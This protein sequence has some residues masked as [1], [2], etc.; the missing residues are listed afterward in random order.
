MASGMILSSPILGNSSPPVIRDKWIW[1][2]IEMEEQEEGWLSRA[3]QRMAYIGLPGTNGVRPLWIWNSGD[4]P[5]EQQSIKMSPSKILG[6]IQE[7]EIRALWIF[8]AGRIDDLVDCEDEELKALEIEAIVHLKPLK[9]PSEIPPPPPPPPPPVEWSP[10]FSRLNMKAH[11]A[12]SPNWSRFKKPQPTSVIQAAGKN[13]PSLQASKK[14]AVQ[15]RKGLSS[16]ISSPTA[17]T[18]SLSP[19][20]VSLSSM[21]SPKSPLEIARMNLRKTPNGQRIFSELSPQPAALPLTMFWEKKSP[22]QQRSKLT[23]PAKL[24]LSANAG[25]Q[26]EPLCA[27]KVS[28]SRSSAKV[29]SSPKGLESF[30]GWFFHTPSAISNSQR[31]YPSRRSTTKE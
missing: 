24:P 28:S 18:A 3:N 4:I 12:K 7:E 30:G 6:P 25:Y 11:E 5:P 14:P 2:D 20:S 26:N 17:T 29:L 9:P 27:T 15:C 19:Q 16:P 13:L 22:P 10:V 31:I 21:E 8:K 1:D 23:L